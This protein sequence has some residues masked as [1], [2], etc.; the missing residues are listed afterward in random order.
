MLS[1][2]LTVTLCH[3][4]YISHFQ[5]HLFTSIPIKIFNQVILKEKLAVERRGH[6]DGSAVEGLNLVSADRKNIGQPSVS[7]IGLQRMARLPSLFRKNQEG[8]INQ[9]LLNLRK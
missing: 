6:R 7:G 9:G 8:K 5:R 4:I 2:H 1:F 3:A